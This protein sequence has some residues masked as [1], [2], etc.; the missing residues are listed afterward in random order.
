MLLRAMATIASAILEIVLLS[1]M[2]T[3]PVAAQIPM[4]LPPSRQDV[5]AREYQAPPGIMATPN[6]NLAIMVNIDRDSSPTGIAMIFSLVVTNSTD[7]PITPRSGAP[8]Y[9]FHVTSVN[10]QQEVWFG[11]YAVL[12]DVI[13]C[14]FR[15][16]ETVIFRLPW[17][18]KTFPGF[19]QVPPGLYVVTAE[20]GLVT[21][22][23]ALL[24]IGDPPAGEAVPLTQGCNNV[25]LTWPAG[26][27]LATVVAA[28][29]PVSSLDAVWR[30]NN[31]T[32]AFAGYSPRFPAASDFATAD[33]LTPVFVC[34]RA[35]GSLT[36]PAA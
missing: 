9:R 1:L 36:R 2:H 30:F 17:D 20:Y 34:M 26:T 25:T 18:Q 19:R 24:A 33:R 13:F 14:T 22:V 21:A 12:P 31:P 8:G 3:P 35:P 15:P 5:C 16:K 7:A 10:D 11:P 29:S 32:Q 27:S 4:P 23:P 6:P 28:L